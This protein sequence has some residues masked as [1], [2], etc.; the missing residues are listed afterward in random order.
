MTGA[1]INEGKKNT[2]NISRDSSSFLN[3]PQNNAAQTNPNV[4]QIP[5]VS[6]PKGGGA[7]KS[8]DD[9][10]KVNAVNG[11]ASYSIPLPFSP[12]RGGTAPSLS[13]SYNSGSGNSPFGIGWGAELPS[14]RRKT[15]KELPQYRDAEESDSFVFSGV[16]DLVPQLIL[17]GKSNWIK[18]SV[19]VNNV[20]ITRYVPRTEGGFAKI[21]KLEDNGNTYWKITSPQ[22]IVSVFGKTDQA[23]I[24]SPFAGEN[25]KIFRWCLEYGYDDKGNFTSYYYKNE[26]K[27][28][29]SFSPFEMNRL[30]DL[31]PFTNI[32]LKGIKYGNSIAWYEGDA[33]PSNYLFEL[34]MD[35]GE[36]DVVKPTTAETNKWAARQ[37]PFSD[38]KAGFE[39]RTYRL[40]RRVLMFHHFIQ[41]LGQQDYLVKSLEFVYDELPAVTY[42]MSVKEA[43]YIWNADGTLHSSRSLPPIEFAYY[44]PGYSRTVQ[45]ISPENIANAP[46]GL[47][48]SW[49][50]IDLN[51]EGISGIL[52]EQSEEWFYKENLGNGQFSPAKIVNKRPSFNGLSD[53]HLAIQD[54]EADGIKYAVYNSPSMKGYFEFSPAGDWRSF[55]PFTNY[56]NI[57]LRDPNIKFLDLNGD[58]MPDMLISKEQ[59]F[60]WYE[61]KG[62]DGYNNYHLTSMAT[63]DEKGPRIVFA[64]Q[65][66]HLVIAI[67]DMTG[68]GLSDIVLITYSS[69]CY[70]PNLGFG[71][72]GAKVHMQMNG[73]FDAQDRFNQRM[74]HFAD[75]DGTGTTDI[76]YAG[77]NEIQVW[78][79][80]SGNS[81]SVPY[82]FFNPFAAW[83]EQAR[84]SMVDL[85]GNG[86]ACMV[87][88]SPLPANANSPLRYIDIMGGRKPHI[89]SSYKNNMGREVA[90]E[91]QSSTQ[92]YLDDKKN[93]MQWVTKLPFPV[94]C[95]KKV[96]VT[97]LVSQTRFTNQYNYHHGYY[98]AVE[99]EFRGFAMVEQT[100]TEE[101]DNYVQQTTAAG[102]TNSTEKD[103][104]QPAVITKS[105]FH[106]GAYIRLKH[107]MHQLSEN[108]YPNA[109][110]NEG[111]I[112]DP[113]IIAQLQKLVLPDAPFPEGLA[114]AERS[115]CFR[116]LKGLPLRQEIYSD[117]GDP[118]IQRHPYAVT[119]YNYNIRL[120]QPKEQQKYAV[121][122]THEKE[123]LTVNFERNPADPRI[124]HNINI[125]IDPYG[126]VLQGAAV[127]Y[128]RLNPDMQLPTDN[129]RSKQTQQWVVYTQNSFT[130]L[131]DNA[132]AYRL[133]VLYDAQ[134]WELNAGLPQQ[135]FFKE[136]ELEQLF[137]N[138]TVKLYQ[139]Q[140]AL[141][142]KRKLS[143]ARTYF[144]KNDLSGPM[145]AGTIDTLALP[146][147]N[148]VLA[149]TPELVADIYGHAR[150]T[151]PM[152]INNAKYTHLDGDNNY[153]IESGEIFYYP[154]LTSA[155]ALTVIPPPGA[156]DISFAKSNFY[157][158]VAYEDNF[159]NL[160]K[161]FY[162]PY[163]LFIKRV[164]DPLGN[165]TNV[166]LFSYRTLSPW[167]LRDANDNRTGV[168]FDELGLVSQ[169]FV[170]GKETE[171]RG[172]FMDMASTEVSAADRPGSVLMYDFRYYTSGGVLPNR[173]SVTVRENHYYSK[174][175]PGTQADLANWLQN[176][177]G[178]QPDTPQT[179]NNPVWQTSYSYSDGAGNEVLKKVQAAPGL[180]PQRDVKGNLLKDANGNIVLANTTPALRWVGNGRTIVNNKGKAVKQ[181]E[182]FFDSSP[183]YNNE[184]ELVAI[185][186]TPL[187]YYD[188]VGRLIRT[189]S[190][191]GTFSKVEFDAW[192]Q[193]SWDQND[194]VIDSEWYA[195]RISGSMGVQEQQAAQKAAV[196]YNTPS[197]VYT[198]SLG[199]PFLSV[200]H[201]KTQRSNEA[202]AIEAFFYNRT[203]LD[204]QGLALS[205]TDSRNNTVMQWK[206]N[207][208]GH[209]GYQ[210]SMD[211]GERW[212]LAD[213]M[214]KSLHLWDSRQQTFSY[215]YDAL[216][217]PLNIRV[218]TGNTATDVTYEQFIYG[219]TLPNA[220]T[221]NLLGKLYTHKD[222]AGVTSNVGC[223]FKGNIAGASRQLLTDYKNTPDW[224]TAP[225]LDNPVYTSYAVVDALNRPVVMFTPDASIFIPGYDES[226]LLKSEDVKL[227]GVGTVTNFISSITYNAKGQRERILY[228]NNTVTGYNYNTE[229]YRLTRLLTTAG[230]GQNILQ[231][232]NYTYDPVGNIT[233]VFDN[234]QQTIFYNGQQVLPQSYYTYDALYQLV[235]GSGR[236]HTGQVGFGNNDNYD[237]SWCLIPALQ[238]NS[239][240]QM[241]NYTQKYFY[242]GA[243]NIITMQHIAD[244]AGSWTRNYNYNLNNNQLVNTMVGS[245]N[246]NSSYNYTYNV[247]GSMMT[248]PQLPG[249]DWNFRE[250][251]Q[252]VNL[253][254]GG[255][256]YYIYDSGGQRARKIIV[257]NDGMVAERI[258]L[259]RYEIYRERD[260]TGNITL[261]R[262]TL[263]V[264][265]DKQR[266]AIVETLTAGNDGSPQQLIRY[267]YSNH[268]GS[269][270]LELDE[271]S[272]I[273]S[274][275]EYHPYGTSSYRATDSSRQV[276]LKRYRYTGM[277]R[278][279]ETGLEYHSARYYLPWLG[280][281]MAADPIGIEDGLN[282][283]L[284]VKSNPII[285]GDINGT[286][287][288]S[289]KGVSCPDVPADIDW[290]M[291]NKRC[292]EVDRNISRCNSE[293]ALGFQN[294]EESKEPSSP[295]KTTPQ[296]TNDTHQHLANPLG[297]LAS[298]F[299]SAG[300]IRS[301]DI[302]KKIRLGR[303]VT[304]LLTGELP[305]DQVQRIAISASNYRKLLRTTDQSSGGV[306]NRVISRSIDKNSNK[307]AVDWVNGALN[308]RKGEQS[309][310]EAYRTVAS[311]ASVGRKSANLLGKASKYLGAFLAF[312]GM[313]MSGYSFENNLEHGHW[314]D[315]FVDSTTFVSSGLAFGGFILGSTL[316]ENAAWVIGAFGIGVLIGTA[317]N[318][319]SEKLYGEKY[320][321][322]GV[323]ARGMNVADQTFSAFLPQNKALPNYKQ[324][325]RV[326]WWLIDTFNQ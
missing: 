221:L 29:I 289:S 25:D 268:L 264:A 31:A 28:N 250:E 5:A 203:E 21:E 94:Q 143:Q 232:L 12:G 78:F 205:V 246:N 235:E 292:D 262:D 39:L 309:L 278:D 188:A 69:V 127:V 147:Q 243:G 61:A 320:S 47:S 168:R 207:M 124:A 129:D 156:A 306:L 202:A 121:F 251:M 30:N 324:K 66:E 79:N 64:D 238:P 206:Y 163:K 178:G 169:T 24:R 146:C 120:V 305:L 257:R 193:L 142:D 13:L 87:W 282:V 192:S 89:M 290:E 32:Y 245:Q 223:D 75:V 294:I 186:V 280:R 122:F 77:N 204:I 216:H 236:E 228:G 112:S 179:D 110:I 197:V 22:N 123:T 266:I 126:N 92:Y 190:P 139:E 60:M 307:T 175:V 134:A 185:G 161:T 7:I 271:L 275:E 162:D 52:T 293:N 140:T 231:D 212:M 284:Y 58:G 37:D 234:S 35:Y 241:R 208:L 189:E 225:S 3:N 154:D 313:L 49:Q 145:L 166:D 298:E 11:T 249:I 164:L 2:D 303:T 44:K 261:Q 222:T 46:I 211:A 311:N 34:S 152:M 128:G 224:N 265:D 97:D 56:P 111:V 141:N 36:H 85:L 70:Y 226:N 301:I 244:T 4:I 302:A 115:E 171:Y 93:G 45:E 177:F 63:D 102:V 321:A 104:F 18:N 95:I 279:D 172:D 105:W 281:W 90:F 276:P 88:S 57:D 98:D 108:Y 151:D 138:A 173:V 14:I 277:E 81:F 76:I 72:F 33:L 27:D 10:F 118:A 132:Q 82:D 312:V 71:R 256:A 158:P 285:H 269:A 227:K 148:Y 194:T 96:V 239:P 8:I 59:E 198:D 149:F 107:M 220:K 287:C 229:T 219:E 184:N 136:A 101:F 315:A 319:S 109:L 67:A 54:M 165:E 1:S 106:T 201:N 181:Y 272:K 153:W 217:R 174:P 240:A 283:Y 113:G 100:D 53:G 200:A 23:K 254:G 135:Y 180:A 259:G 314:F 42:L 286:D 182:P 51:S 83:D 296:T 170:M 318:F 176:L 19:V 84:F 295:Q 160:T 68:D 48:G 157:L 237:D 316:L 326:A 291:V 137:N 20:V 26:N 40:C 155:P 260:N 167:L 323:I 255:D 299:I 131:M 233:S 144:L 117:E 317:I 150:V 267:Q 9:K 288:D 308:G 274:Y 103:L 218:N 258:Y 322:A 248:M 41:D 273:I 213:V 43:G 73:I 17:D 99:R 119:Q 230:F 325:N 253:V 196:H 38:Y 310:D 263:H 80:Q 270:C 215:D 242:D 16:E 116:A 133:P 74:L 297:Y 62:K 65:D 247:H 15:E 210:N 191:D 183:E 214:G 300:Q 50:W 195:K 125:E 199:R 86:T 304:N 209:I 114:A 187:L 55:F 6:L 252:H 159:G 91:Y 130:E